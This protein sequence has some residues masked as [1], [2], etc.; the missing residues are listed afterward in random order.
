MEA[1]DLP[2]RER[3]LAPVPLAAGRV[4]RVS[5]VVAS[6]NYGRYLG[7]CLDSVLG[8]EG[9]VV[10]V[11]VVDDASTDDTAAVLERFA[12][13]AR[14]TVVRHS[15]NVGHVVSFNDGFEAVTADYAVKLDADDLLPPGSLARATA[16]LDE[17]PAVGFVY[18]RPLHFST[19]RPP[20]ARTEVES[21]TI[22]PGREWLARCCRTATNRLTSPEAV[23]RTSMV[24]EVGPYRLDLPHTYD[25]LRFLELSVV[26]D[27]GRVRGPD[28]GFY[29]VHPASQQ[30]TVHASVVLD[31]Q[32]RLGAFE[33]VFGGA[34]GRLPDGTALHRSA[35]IAL[36]TE[37]L[38]RG[39]RAYERGR[40]GEV[41]ID[42]LVEFALVAWPCAERLPQW[43]ALERRRR[44]GTKAAHL[45]PFVARAALRRTVDEVRRWRWQR[46]GL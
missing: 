26:A 46:T 35:R 34:G 22:W 37:A 8:Q 31:L 12:D 9:V 14:I 2:S 18:G 19:E 6:Y 25:F 43:R 4:P 23:M 28:Q 24:A 17:H 29:R 38:S 7:A 11:V 15:R 5:V 30:R 41:P 10:D 21:W 1:K 39:C 13:D 3:R 32:E 40:T 42:E 33:A 44:V 36:A 27:V 16:L 45:P 20:A